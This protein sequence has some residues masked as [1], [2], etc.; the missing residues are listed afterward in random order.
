MIRHAIIAVDDAGFEI[1]LSVHDALLVHIKKKG[2]AKK[3]L[4]LV[5][6]MEEASEK[7]IGHKIP[8]EIKVIR[9]HFYQSDS[10]GEK[11]NKLYKKYLEAKNKVYGF[12]T[13]VHE[14][15]CTNKITP[16]HEN[17]TPVPV[18]NRVI[19]YIYSRGAGHD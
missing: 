8:V 12:N 14:Q 19:Q 11:W 7:V 9:K 1:S 3:I 10:D 17:I 13:P 15:R 4:K 6:L 18:T 5:Q 16:R 2:W